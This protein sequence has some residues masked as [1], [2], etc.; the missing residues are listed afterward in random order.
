LNWFRLSEKLIEVKFCLWQT[1]VTLSRGDARERKHCTP[2]PK[3]LHHIDIGD[4]SLFIA[5]GRRR[6]FL[7]EQK[8]GS[9]V[10]ENSKWGITEN[11]GRIR[12]GNHSNFLGK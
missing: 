2:P 9:V 1:V 3:T 4:R 5:W 8:R 6:G 7:G 12:R 10:T 11:F